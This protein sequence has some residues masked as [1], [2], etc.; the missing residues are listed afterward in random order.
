MNEFGKQRKELV[1]NLCANRYIKTDAVK[2][3]MLKVKRELFVMTGYQ[4]SAYH[5]I[6]LP[7]PPVGEDTATISQQA[8]HAMML[9]G[10]RL[11]K[12]NKV[13]EIGCGSGI[14]LAYIREIVGRTGVSA[15][16]YS[17]LGIASAQYSCS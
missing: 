15:K 9:E 8:V 6:A 5:D 2:K 10:L 14:T 13:V 16:K 17:H 4:Y 1:E 11:K 12:G 3:A 7:I